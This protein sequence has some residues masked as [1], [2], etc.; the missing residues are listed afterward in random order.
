SGFRSTD[1]TAVDKMSF[2]VPKG[3][4][5]AIVGESGSGK[6][7]AAKM[8]LRLETKTSG[9]ILVNGRDTDTLSRPELQ[10]LRREM[11]PVF[12]DPYS[13]LDPRQRIDRIIG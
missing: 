12:Q 13:S 1:F 7:T 9:S 8:L 4:T 2:Q 10:A 11:Q 6:S 5:M 3:S